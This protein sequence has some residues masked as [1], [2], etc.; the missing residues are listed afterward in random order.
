MLER[1]KLELLMSVILILCACILAER[2]WE[3]ASSSRVEEGKGKKT[4]VIDAGH[5]GRK[6]GRMRWCL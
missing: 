5:G 2:G 1:R 6:K 3:R 4:V